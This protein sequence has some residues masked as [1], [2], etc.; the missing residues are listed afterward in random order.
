MAGFC[1]IM[2]E[3]KKSQQ[4]LLRSIPCNYINQDACIP[5]KSQVPCTNIY[6][7]HASGIEVK[8]LVI[9]SQIIKTRPENNQKRIDLSAPAIRAIMFYPARVS[10]T[11]AQPG[12]YSGCVS[13][14]NFFFSILFLLSLKPYTYQYKKVTNE[15]V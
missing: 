8:H 15:H 7:H 6:G 1:R 12:S 3:E 10:M 5:R 13:S 4:K 2:A 11:N 14:K 9:Q